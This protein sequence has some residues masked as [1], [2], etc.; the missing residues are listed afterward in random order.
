MGRKTTELPKIELLENEKAEAHKPLR[1]VPGLWNYSMNYFKERGKPFE[2]K[3][4]LICS[5][6]YSYYNGCSFENLME[7]EELREAAEEYG[8]RQIAEWASRNYPPSRYNYDPPGKSDGV[9]LI[10]MDGRWVCGSFEGF[11]EP[12]MSKKDDQG[13][14]GL[15]FRPYRKKYKKG[16]YQNVLWE[17]NSKALPFLRPRVPGIIA[18]DDGELAKLPEDVVYLAKDFDEAWRAAR[19]QY[20]KH[21]KKSGAAQARAEEEEKKKSV[22]RTNARMEVLQQA[23]HLRDVLDTYI[24]CVADETMTKEQISNVFSELEKLGMLNKTMKQV[25]GRRLKEK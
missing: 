8:I 24:K 18:E 17:N 16:R 3:G 14:T 1:S 4:Y 11:V 25:Y 20:K 21:L 2:Y 22:K 12:D 23:N 19:K 7:N 5:S 6:Q 15:D 10:F 9:W 13:R